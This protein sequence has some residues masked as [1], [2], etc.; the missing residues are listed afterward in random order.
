MRWFAVNVIWPRPDRVFVDLEYRPNAFE[1]LGGVSTATE[2][3][4]G[5]FDH[6]VLRWFYADTGAQCETDAHGNW[7]GAAQ[8]AHEAAWAAVRKRVNPDILLAVRE[9][10]ALLSG[11]IVVNE[12]VY[13]DE[14]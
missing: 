3:L 4:F 1:R 7:A 12:V 13:A 10:A 11:G 9:T 6:G 14:K 2:R 8:L 5:M